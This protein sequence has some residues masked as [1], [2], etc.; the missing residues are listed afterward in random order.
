[1]RLLPTGTSDSITVVGATCPL[2]RNLVD[3]LLATGFH[4]HGLYRSPHKLLST[5]KRHPAFQGTEFDLINPGA[6]A[7]ALEMSKT[8]VWLAQY[9]EPPTTYGQDLNQIALSAVCSRAVHNHRKIVLL[10]SGGAV[11]GNPNLLPVSEDHPCRPLNAYGESKRKLEDTLRAHVEYR[12]DLSGVILRCGNIYGPNYL[13]SDAMGCIRAFT[14]AILNHRP[15]VLIGRGKAVRDFVHVDDVSRAILSAIM[16][17]HVF[18]V[19]NVACGVGIPI[20]RTLEMTSEMLGCAPVD[21]INV[22]APLTDVK[23]IVL[24]IERINRDCAWRPQTDLREGLESMLI[25][26]REMELTPFNQKHG[27]ACPYGEA[28]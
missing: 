5:W 4:V 12:A 17:D 23:D 11:Y 9:R 18:A 28:R 19:W 10:S 6:L 26:L 8:I 2:G 25:P 21:V 3:S 22:D 1:M 7:E 20:I 16:C 27:L 13:A 24:N 14:L 15:V